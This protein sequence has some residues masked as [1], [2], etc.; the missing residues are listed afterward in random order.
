MGKLVG[1]PRGPIKIPGLSTGP[2]FLCVEWLM[3]RFSEKMVGF[4]G[5]ARSGANPKRALEV[6]QME[7]L[8]PIGL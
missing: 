7:K 2:A 4:G 8:L 1:T 6:S 3:K 5:R